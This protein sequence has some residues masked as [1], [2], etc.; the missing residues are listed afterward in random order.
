MELTLSLFVLA[1]FLALL[2]QYLSISLG[3]CYGI[4]L[5][6]MLLILG[7]SPLHV[8]PAVLLSQLAGGIVGGLAYQRAG[9]IKLYFNRVE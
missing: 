7:L 8:V 3:M 2:C 5:T 9:N 1:V 4:L 6:R